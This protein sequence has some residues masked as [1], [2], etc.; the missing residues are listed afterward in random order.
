[1]LQTSKLRFHLGN[2]HGHCDLM[3]KH[4]HNTNNLQRISRLKI[5]CN[6]RERSNFVLFRY[7]LWI[8][9]VVS[10]LLLNIKA[11]DYGVK[12]CRFK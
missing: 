9:Y 12:I 11:Q 4:E 7:I 3:V 8:K 10:K 6:L 2:G 1:M 5:V